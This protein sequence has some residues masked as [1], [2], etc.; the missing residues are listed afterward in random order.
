MSALQNEKKGQKWV[1][2][3]LFSFKRIGILTCKEPS[4]VHVLSF[5]CAAHKN[6]KSQPFGCASFYCWLFDMFFYYNSQQGAFISVMKT[7]WPIVRKESCTS[8]IG[9]QVSLQCCRKAFCSWSQHVSVLG[10]YAHAALVLLSLIRT[11]KFPLV[12]VGKWWHAQR[13]VANPGILPLPAH[14]RWGEVLVTVPFVQ[15]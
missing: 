8:P 12:H 2:F 3:F 6:R 11:S 13:A 10:D 4:A 7:S 15:H 14:K 1:A 9:S 5:L